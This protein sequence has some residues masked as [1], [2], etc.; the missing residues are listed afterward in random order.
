MKR[1]TSFL[2]IL[3]NACLLQGR[4]AP[5]VCGTDSGT[6]LRE[7]HLHRISAAGMKK[8]VRARNFAAAASLPDIGNLA[9]ID[10]QDG[11]VAR[12]SPFN[13]RGKTVRFLPTKSDTSSYRYELAD[14]DYDSD[15]ANS[16]TPIADI[17]DDDTRQI[18]L[19]F[20]FPFYG[21]QYRSIFVN[22]DGNLTFHQGDKDITNRSLGRMLAGAPRIAPLFTDLDP[23]R[24]LLGITVVSQSKRVVISWVQVPSYQDYGRGPLQTFQVR[25]YA[26]GKIE[27]AFQDILIDDAITGISPG[28]Q[29]GTPTLVSFL[30]ASAAA[31]DGAVAAQFSNNPRIDPV[32]VAQRFYASHEDAY[33][34]LVIYNNLD[35]M[36]DTNAVAYEITVRNSRK[37]FG[38]KMVDVGDETGSRQRLQ[39]LINMGPVNQY[40]AD[41][42]EVVPLRF[43]S[44]DTPLSVLAHEAG[45]LFL[46]FA[47]IVD[48]SGNKPMLGRAN[49][50]WSFNFN[51]DASFLEGNKIQDNGPGATP[52]FTTTETVRRYSA[53]DQYLMGFRSPA[54]VPDTFYVANA[55]SGTG[56]RMPEAGIGFDGSRVNVSIGD[57]LSA[58]GRRVP[59]Y[60]VSQRHF[61]FA[62]IL[63]VAAGTQPTAKDVAKLEAYRAQFEQLYNS[64]SSG[65]AYAETTLTK[66]LHITTY[67]AAGVQEGKAAAARIVLDSSRSTPLTVLLR[68][69]NGGIGVPASV[70]V[71]AGATEITFVITGVRAGVDTLRAEAAETGYEAAWSRIQVATAG[72]VKMSVASGDHQTGQAG[73]VLPQPIAFQVT[74]VNELPY[75]G[76]TVKVSVSGGGS[77]NVSSA[78][79]NEDGVAEFRWM[80]GPG[81]VNE[82]TATAESGAT[83]TA[84]VLGQPSF[85][86]DGVVNAASFTPGLVPG[87]IGTIFGANLAGASTDAFDLR[88][89]GRSATV[90]YGDSKQINFFVP[91]DLVGPS[92]SVVVKTSAGTSSP[93]A[94]P[95]LAVQPGVFFDAGSGFGTILTSG[96]GSLTQVNP[97]PRG[98]YVEVYATGL[99]P[100]RPGFAAAPTTANS[101]KST[102]AGVEADVLFSGQ[103][104]GFPG[105]DQVNVR[106]PDSVPAGDQLLVLT[107]NGISSN[108]AKIRVR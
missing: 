7:L 87:A 50:H 103:A 16:G 11:T 78:V 35:V 15:V 53:L 65:N 55:T 3:L 40:P 88:V 37:G 71:P 33:D 20:P 97:V 62:F 83:A 69:E 2:V 46:A 60:T 96:T 74:D 108:P 89:G 51:S 76:V 92:T 9:I 84:S 14:Q 77:V 90:F 94:V 104:P 48:E 21:Q 34:Y 68:S 1:Y 47:S 102:I 10:D 75:P 13:L 45:H 52:R 22:S 43:T 100:L 70:T 17:G 73:A 85:I 23:T 107:V 61:R 8:S 19:P 82:L 27:F 63:V 106:V 67:P 24:A 86:A 80:P 6:D 57:I 105:L 44:R 79:T 4:Q 29:Q 59:D 28:K 101:V 38:D 95:L 36:A 41:P 5:V 93:V 54:E 56:A 12:R 26:D 30:D 98:G 72:D 32:V 64:A 99:G 18:S 66:A 81:A 42:N 39:A 31:Y 25:L 49:V 91:A 58:E